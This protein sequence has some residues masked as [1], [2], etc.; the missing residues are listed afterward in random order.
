MGSLAGLTAALGLQGQTLLSP[1]SLLTMLLVCTSIGGSWPPPPYHQ[2]PQRFPTNTS[3]AWFCTC[4]QTP[5]ML[6]RS[7]CE[8]SLQKSI[9]TFSIS[10]SIPQPFQKTLPLFLWYYQAEAHLAIHLHTPKLMLTRAYSLLRAYFRLR[11]H[12]LAVH[13]FPQVHQALTSHLLRVSD[14]EWWLRY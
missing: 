5:T 12:P 3:H 6:K 13:F 1:T 4:L 11:N 8:K 9:D 7:E 14:L 2:S 10:L